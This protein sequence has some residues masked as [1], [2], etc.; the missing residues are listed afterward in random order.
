[1]PEKH[2]KKCSTSLAITE[3]QIKMTLRSHLTSVRMAKISNTMVA[4]ASGSREHSYIAGVYAH[5]Y[6]HYGN[7]Y[8]GSSE[9]GICPMDA[10][11]YHNTC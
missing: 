11:F 1:M 8:G 10:A 9:K 3:I 6:S 4:H 7:Q 5:F 2:L